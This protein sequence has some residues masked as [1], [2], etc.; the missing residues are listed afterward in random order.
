MRR[1]IL[2][3][4]NAVA[5]ALIAAVVLATRDDGSASAAT[6]APVGA[7]AWARVISNGTFDATRSKN[8]TS[9]TQPS[10]G[11]YCIKTPVAVKNV[12]ATVNAVSAP[13]IAMAGIVGGTVDG[14]I[15]VPGRS[16]IFVR[17]LSFGASGP[18]APPRC[19]STS[20]FTSGSRRSGT[21]RR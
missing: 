8:I 14:G 17:T 11:I 9:I 10:T 3:L 21:W 4:F 6:S 20:W 16:K 2:I 15:S 1:A 5:I 12:S 18:P 13:A 19:R 7:K